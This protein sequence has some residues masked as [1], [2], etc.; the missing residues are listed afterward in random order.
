VIV[1]EH[2]AKTFVTRG[3]EQV[4][5]MV[6]VS[7]EV[8]RNE[9]VCLVGPSGCG[10][11]TLLRLVAGLVAP[12]GGTISIGGTKVTEPRDDTGIV[13]QAASKE[14]IRVS[15]PA[16]CSSVPGYAGRWCTIPRFC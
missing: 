6:D 11:S 13:F 7:L 15:C 14:S 9:F 16:G 2:V 4:A 10:K 12:T 8:R 5:A 1:L 3:G